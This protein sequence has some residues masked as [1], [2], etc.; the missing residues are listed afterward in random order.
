MKEKILLICLAV[1]MFSTKTIYSQEIV[2]DEDTGKYQSQIVIENDSLSKVQ[3]F[4]KAM[5]WVVIN[6]KSAKD[7]VQ[8]SNREAGKIICKGTFSTMLF[9]KEGWIGHTLT[10]EFKEGKFRQ[11]YSDFSYASG[12]TGEI[13]FESDDM[14]FKKKLLKETSANI[15]ASTEDIKIFFSTVT[16]EDDW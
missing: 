13:A 15:K 12:T 9:W 3:Q 5:E 8:Y 10:F 6:Y 1:C 7:V 2:L 14:G 16:K 11:T 4:D